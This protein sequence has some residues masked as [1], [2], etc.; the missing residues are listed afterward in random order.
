M[1][2]E[3]WEVTHTDNINNLDRVFLKQDDLRR[4]VRHA[5]ISML[6][7]VTCIY[8]YS[9]EKCG[10]NTSIETRVIT[11][12]KK[13]LFFTHQI[14]LTLIQLIISRLPSVSKENLWAHSL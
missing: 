2:D 9:I 1:C 13:M 7:T 8:A 10:Q 4:A 5:L 6:L 3:W 14:F 11:K 12:A